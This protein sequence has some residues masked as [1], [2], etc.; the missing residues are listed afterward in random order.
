MNQAS[1]VF[2]SHGGYKADFKVGNSFTTPEGP[3][4][5]H[6]IYVYPGTGVVIV[7]DEKVV[8]ATLPW[9][10]IYMFTVIHEAEPLVLPQS[11]VVSLD[12]APLLSQ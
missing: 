8:R 4:T 9:H 5:I 10:S 12:G 11:N 3:F 1:Q 6:G 7:D 2:T